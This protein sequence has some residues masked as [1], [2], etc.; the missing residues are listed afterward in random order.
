M[1]RIKY[2]LLLLFT[3]SFLTSRG[4]QSI[5]WYSQD[6]LLKNGVY[7]NYGF[8]SE[9]KEFGVALN[10]NTNQILTYYVPIKLT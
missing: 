10:N 6:T 7:K 2:L 5:T 8:I 9:P 4:D 3:I 1:H